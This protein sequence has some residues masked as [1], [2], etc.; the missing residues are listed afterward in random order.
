MIF[1]LHLSWLLEFGVVVSCAGNADVRSASIGHVTRPGEAVAAESS[2]ERR[3]CRLRIGEMR[4]I[5]F[6]S[7]L[8]THFIRYSQD[9]CGEILTALKVVHICGVEV[10]LL[11][12]TLWT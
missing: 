5:G 10:R 4:A 2:H 8:S 12:S 1:L 11:Y 6:S 3:M 9:K 7:F